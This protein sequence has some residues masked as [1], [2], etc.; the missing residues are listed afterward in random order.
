MKILFIVT[1]MNKISV[2][3]R[4]LVKRKVLPATYH[5]GPAGD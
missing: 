1:A 2:Q 3:K 4:G 5:K